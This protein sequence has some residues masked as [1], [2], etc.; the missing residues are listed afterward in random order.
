M[1]RRAGGYDMGEIVVF[2]VGIFLIVYLFASVIR[3]ER[4]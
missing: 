1:Q 3:P 2:F 4:F